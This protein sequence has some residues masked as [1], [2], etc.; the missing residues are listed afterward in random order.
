MMFQQVRPDKLYAMFPFYHEEMIERSNSGERIGSGFHFDPATGINLAIEVIEEEKVR[1]RLRQATQG[2]SSQAVVAGGY[3][4]GNILATWL[5]TSPTATTRALE[6]LQRHAGSSCVGA[7]SCPPSVAQMEAIAKELGPDAI[8]WHQRHGT[9][10]CVLPG[11]GHTVINRSPCVKVAIDSVRDSEVHLY[12]MAWRLH[13]AVHLRGQ[14][15]CKTPIDYPCW[16]QHV[17]T[18]CTI[19]DTWM[20]RDNNSTTM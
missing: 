8:I 16:L 20:T 5:F 10:V 19:P 13:H 18:M 4:T 17:Y 2:T 15:L 12:A 7:D 11:W 9:I 3:P 14:N 1:K 6:A